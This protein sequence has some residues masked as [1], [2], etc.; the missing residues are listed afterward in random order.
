MLYIQHGLRQLLFLDSK[1]SSSSKVN[2]TNSCTT[3]RMSVMYSAKTII[4]S[5]NYI[6][7]AKYSFPLRQHGL[8]LS[9]YSFSLAFRS[10]AVMTAAAPV[11]CVSACSV[12]SFIVWILSPSFLLCLTI[13]SE[14]MNLLLFSS[15]IQT[16]LL[17]LSMHCS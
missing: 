12:F 5:L 9:I 6:D 15:F 16:S 13:T 2:E 11:V 3:P 7:F 14:M 10:S 8:Y 1:F 4:M 17:R